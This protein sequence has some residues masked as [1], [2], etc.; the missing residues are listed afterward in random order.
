MAIEEGKLKSDIT[1]AAERMGMEYGDLAE[2][3]PEV[4]TDCL[5]KS[6]KLTAAIDGGDADQVKAI[7]HDLKGSCANYG[8]NSPSALAK[9]LEINHASPNKAELDQFISEIKQIQGLSL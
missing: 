7:A 8:L 4:L 9:S 6:V 2:M 3:I 1:D 5:A